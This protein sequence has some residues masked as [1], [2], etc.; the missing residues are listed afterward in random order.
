MIDHPDYFRYN[1]WFMN[2][3]FETVSDVVGRLIEK[4]YATEF[5][6]PK[7]V[8]NETFFLNLNPKDFVIDEA[9]FFAEDSEAG[10]DILIMAVSSRKHQ[11]KGILINGFT[12]E[13]SDGMSLWA[14]LKQTFKN[15]L[16]S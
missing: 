15:L 14:S 5:H 3:D 8:K 16:T 2:E 11:V 6:I 7:P 1:F 9:F 10:H 13:A 4:G 12:S